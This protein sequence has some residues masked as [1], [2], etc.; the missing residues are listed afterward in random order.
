MESL[1]LIFIF[2]LFI[3]S[4]KQSLSTT[5]AISRTLQIHHRERSPPSV[6]AA[7]ARSVLLRVLPSHSDSFHFRII[8]KAFQ[9]PLSNSTTFQFVH[10]FLLLIYRSNVEV[11]TVSLLIIILLSQ[12]KGLLRFCTLLFNFFKNCEIDL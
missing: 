12:L 6:Q 1:S 8:S 11:N 9:F 5:V 7:A 4:F 2:S 3:T 10:S